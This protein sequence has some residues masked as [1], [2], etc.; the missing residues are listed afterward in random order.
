MRDAA[1]PLRQ[2][3]E[4]VDGAGLVLDGGQGAEIMRDGMLFKALI[5]WLG[6]HDLGRPETMLVCVRGEPYL[7]TLDRL[8]L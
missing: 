5:K 2:P 6:Q 3:K 8:G 1:K 4:G 7:E